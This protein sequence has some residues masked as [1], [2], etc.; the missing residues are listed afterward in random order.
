MI[1]VTATANSIKIN[2]SSSLD[3]ILDAAYIDNLIGTLDKFN[4]RSAANISAVKQVLFSSTFL[5]PGFMPGP[6]DAYSAYKDMG[7]SDDAE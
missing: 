3:R 2:Q 4:I 5:P 1:V 7:S 6:F